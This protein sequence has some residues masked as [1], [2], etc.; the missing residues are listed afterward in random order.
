MRLPGPKPMSLPAANPAHAALSLG[1]RALLAIVF[2]W[3]GGA[4]A[5]DRQAFVVAVDS[6]RLLARPLVTPVATA[7]PW[8]EIAVGGFLALGLF[9][10]FAGAASAVLVAT[11]LVALGQAMARGLPIDCGCFGGGGVGPGVTWWDIG[12]DVPLLV[13]GL[14][15]FRWPR[16]P[17]ELDGRLF[18]EE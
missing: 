16:G 1:C 6:Y 10:Q 17:F 18:E 11:F 3:A 5:W 2:L 9:V 8:I 15:L 14:Y 7:L 4:K 13:A 12:R